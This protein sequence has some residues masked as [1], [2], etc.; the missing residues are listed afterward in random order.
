MD[1]S[2]KIKSH[3]NIKTEDNKNKDQEFST[4]CTFL[5]KRFE[6]EEKEKRN[7]RTKEILT[8]VG[9]G[10]FLAGLLF[11]P[12]LSRISKYIFLEDNYDRRNFLKGIKFYNI[13]H[14]RRNLI[15]LKKQ[16]MVE[17]RDYKGKPMVIL[18]EKGKKKVMEFAFEKL[19]LKKSQKWDG[20]WRLVIYDVSRRKNVIRDIIRNTLERL[21]FLRLQE[22]VYLTPYP[23]KE[24]VEFLRAYY[25]LEDEI[26]I[27]I[28][29]KFENDET[30]K[31]YFGIP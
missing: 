17:V 15:R 31:E 18:T 26:K 16:K 14:L 21:K 13:I 3:K 9:K 25:N 4:L 23:C 28:V 10:V 7:A 19:S 11:A 29:T 12:K 30:Y 27:L 6:H 24:E 5:I 22:S 1:N 2:Q 8:F 20:K